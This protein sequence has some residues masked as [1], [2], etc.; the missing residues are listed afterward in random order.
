MKI[1]IIGAGA[2]GNTV[3]NYIKERRAQG[4]D[5]ESLGTAE[6]INGGSIEEAFGETPDII[7]DFSNPANIEKTCSYA[8][9][10]GIPAVI[11]TTGCGDTETER[12]KLAAEK[13]PVV[14]SANYSLGITVMAR[15]AEEMT[16]ILGENFDIEI[17]EKH[18]RNKLD[19][20]SGTALLL[21]RAV[22]NKGNYE[23]TYGRYGSER[24]K[25]QDIGI[26]AVRGGGI[27]GE[28]SIIFA[29]D[30]EVIEIK[31]HAA[32]KRIF[33]VGALKA[34]EFAIGKEKGLYDMKDVLCM[35][36]NQ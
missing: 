30:E 29:G 15:I 23:F 36:Q 12:I 32:S 20:P 11:A 1:G 2:M 25:K 8:E 17:V 35:T 34:A 16:D 19:A 24:R 28:H 27:V 9:E 33:A 22:N 26:H 18:H 5:F 31:H 13:V 14:F 3:N 10:H 21:A 4:D 6:L 7:I